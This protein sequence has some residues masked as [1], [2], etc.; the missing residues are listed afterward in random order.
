MR[1]SE[2]I[3]RVRV[4]LSVSSKNRAHTT[5]HQMMLEDSTLPPL[6]FSRSEIVFSFLKLFLLIFTPLFLSNHLL[7]LFLD[8]A[9][10][11]IY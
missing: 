5:R 7:W 1:Q 2:G 10:L 3:H 4:F 9:V 8:L 6:A 11:D